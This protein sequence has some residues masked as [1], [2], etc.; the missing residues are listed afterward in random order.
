[1]DHQAPGLIEIAPGHKVLILGQNQSGKSVLA[2]AIAAAWDAGSLLVYD[3]KE[4]PG[5]LVPN[6]HVAYDVRDA[7]RHLPGRVVWRPRGGETRHLAKN[8]DELCR[9]LL[10]LARRG[11]SSMVVA[12]ETADLTTQY[13]IE[14][15]FAEL[16]RKGANMGSGGHVTLVLVSQ[17]PKGIAVLIRS[18]AQHVA[19]FTLTEQADRDIAAQLLGDV[20]RPELA[21][22]IRA[23]PLPLDHRWWYRGP[24]HRLRLHDPVPFR[25]GAT[26]A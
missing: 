7:L 15:A 23:R 9:K 6:A 17:R 14:P 19:C 3:P 24:D 25:G 21:A 12:H 4:D 8:W 1:M 18:E 2:T 20:E 16:V 11:H 22:A 26:L 10:E 13:R 5:A